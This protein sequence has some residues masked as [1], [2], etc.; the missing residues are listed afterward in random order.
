MSH[1]RCHC[2]GAQ[3]DPHDTTPRYCNLC[4]DGCRLVAVA[5]ILRGSLC[6]FLRGKA[7]LARE[8]LIVEVP[9]TLTRITTQLQTPAVPGAETFE[10]RGRHRRNVP[11]G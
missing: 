9:T 4:R 1:S 7:V 6:P 2:C 5:T 8:P 10:W 3:P 11:G